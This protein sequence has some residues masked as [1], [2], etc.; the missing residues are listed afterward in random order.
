MGIGIDL[1]FYGTFKTATKKK[2]VLIFIVSLLFYT[3]FPVE[4]IIYKYILLDDSTDVIK[5]TR[6]NLRNKVCRHLF[7]A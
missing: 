6:L 2:F 4:L 5:H 1:S 3:L 7:S